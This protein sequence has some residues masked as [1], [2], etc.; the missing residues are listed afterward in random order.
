MTRRATRGARVS[1]VLTPCHL[2]CGVWIAESH[3]N[4]RVDVVPPGV[5]LVAIR[6]HQSSTAQDCWILEHRKNHGLRW[7]PPQEAF[8]LPRSEP[9]SDAFV[10]IPSSMYLVSLQQLRLND[11]KQ[12]GIL[13]KDHIRH[14]VVT[15]LPHINNHC[16]ASFRTFFRDSIENSSPAT[17]ALPSFDASFRGNS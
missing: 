12:L 4:Q 10:S 15:S 11:K 16:F 14:S 8:S 7:P 2:S 1:V 3:H 17:S 13:L 6:C 9:Y 5:P